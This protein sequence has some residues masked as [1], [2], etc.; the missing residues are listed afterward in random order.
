MVTVNASARQR[1]NASARQ[2]SSRVSLTRQRVKGG[3]TERAKITRQRVD[4][5]LFCVL[6]HCIFYPIRNLIDII[7]EQFTVKAQQT[8]LKEGGEGGERGEENFSSSR[9][10]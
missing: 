10:S 3:Y 4:L 1:V 8:L 7:P 9:Y 5:N 6:L 2:K